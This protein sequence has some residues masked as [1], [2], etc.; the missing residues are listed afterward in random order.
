MCECVCG[1]SQH[2]KEAKE[3]RSSYRAHFDG[4]IYNSNDVSSLTPLG[5]MIS[6][7]ISFSQFFFFVLSA[8]RVYVARLHILVFP[9]CVLRGWVPRS[10]RWQEGWVLPVFFS[11]F[12]LQRGEI[13]C[14]KTSLPVLRRKRRG[15]HWLYFFH[16]T[17]ELFFQVLL[18]W[19]HFCV[20]ILCA[21]S[22][23]IWRKKFLKNND[24]KR[25]KNQHY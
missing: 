11:V 5:C 8:V 13:C 21:T 22:G 12:G 18:K 9:P 6:F 2:R 23:E 10:S 25:E 3:N 7:H 24:K 1:S 4:L 17:E 15:K 20:S 14:S 19:F 16:D